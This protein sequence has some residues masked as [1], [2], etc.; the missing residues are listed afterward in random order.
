MV[1][2]KTQQIPYSLKQLLEIRKVKLNGKI[3]NILAA[4]LA[5]GNIKSALDKI[6]NPNCNRYIR[7]KK[8][9]VI[10]QTISKH[11]DKIK[12]EGCKGI[13]K[14]IPKKEMKMLKISEN[15]IKNNLKRLFLYS[16]T[17][18]EIE[19]DS[20]GNGRNGYS[21]KHTANT[22]PI[23]SLITSNKQGKVFFN[24]SYEC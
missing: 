10:L 5:L 22:I 17:P 7:M 19:R 8:L 20:K 1:K 6:E 9:E 14:K 18:K 21:I 3:E 12:I 16:K 11:P 2:G 13:V 15:Y 24:G 23:V 4:E